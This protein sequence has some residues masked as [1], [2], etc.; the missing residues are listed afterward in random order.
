MMFVS[1]QVHAEYGPLDRPAECAE[2]EA[3][4]EATVNGACLSWAFGYLQG[5]PLLPV[6]GE[7]ARF[8]NV[9][10]L[11]VDLTET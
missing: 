8:G 11:G 2:L 3:T 9:A 6:L 4:K 7:L 1:V 10:S 5:L